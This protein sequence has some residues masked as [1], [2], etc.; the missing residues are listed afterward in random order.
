MPE[1]MVMEGKDCWFEMGHLHLV[2][3]VSIPWPELLSPALDCS[4]CQKIRMN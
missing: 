3:M 4:N 2:R 1:V